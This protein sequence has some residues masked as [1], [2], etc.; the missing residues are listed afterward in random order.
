[1][2]KTTCVGDDSFQHND[3][4]DNHNEENVIE[5]IFESSNNYCELNENA[6]T[7]KENA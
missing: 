3:Y 1:M 6:S 5:S 7:F 2:R 4:K